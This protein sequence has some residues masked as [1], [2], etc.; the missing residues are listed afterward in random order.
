MPDM[1]A[2]ESTNIE[3]VGYDE[4]QKALHVL[5][6]GR[7]I[8]YVYQDVPRELFDAMMRADSK[9][10]YLSRMIK[11]TYEFTKLEEVAME[12]I[13]DDGGADQFVK[14]RE[15]LEKHILG[16]EHEHGSDDVHEPVT[17]GPEESVEP[18]PDDWAPKDHPTLTMTRP[19]FEALQRL[20]KNTPLN[21]ED[22]SVVTIDL[23][24]SSAGVVSMETCIRL[25]D[26]DDD[27]GGCYGE[28]HNEQCGD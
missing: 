19:I 14:G 15:H 8:V 20:L 5:F 17:L 18:V 2:V 12:P 1:H 26:D 6:K 11:G 25:P 28:G 21:V 24:E 10:A 9:G 23:V 13:P 3:S 22:G 16:E 4:F 27:D 7:P